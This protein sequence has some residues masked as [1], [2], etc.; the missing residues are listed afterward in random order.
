[1]VVALAPAF[2]AGIA[3]DRPD[4]WVLPARPVVG[5]LSG[6]L[7]EI[8]VGDAPAVLRRD[9]DVDVLGGRRATVSC[10]VLA[11]LPGVLAFLVA[12]AVGLLDEALLVSG[13][14]YL[15]PRGLTGGLFTLLALLGPPRYVAG[16]AGGALRTSRGVGVGDVVDVGAQ[17]EGL[18]L[19]KTLPSRPGGALGGASSASRPGGA[20]LTDGGKPRRVGVAP[21]DFVAV[22]LGGHPHHPLA[23]LKARY[24]VHE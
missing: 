22:D 14:L 7:A 18:I 13:V 11:P 10:E 1:V 19:A 17:D 12:A 2:A 15:A 24:V 8:L 4:V 6:N 21:L 20:L 9:D 5:P 16:A 3:V 23:H